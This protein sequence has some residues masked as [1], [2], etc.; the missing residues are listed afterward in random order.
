MF[1]L[2]DLGLCRNLQELNVSD[3]PTLN[4][5][6]KKPILLLFI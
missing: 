4:S 1:N 3:C 5:E 2:F 6:Y